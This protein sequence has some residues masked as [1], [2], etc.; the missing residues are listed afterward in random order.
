MIPAR[1]LFGSIVEEIQE[2][3]VSLRDCAVEFELDG[4]LNAANGR[5][6]L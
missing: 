6:D 5:N 4:C 3:V 1:K 2:G